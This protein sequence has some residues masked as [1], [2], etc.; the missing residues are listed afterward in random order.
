MYIKWWVE[1]DDEEGGR[2]RRGR[3]ADS[4]NV[5]MLQGL[6]EWYNLAPPKAKMLLSL[7]TCRRRWAM[8][9]FR[10]FV[11]SKTK[12]TTQDILTG[13]S[14]NINIRVTDYDRYTGSAPRQSFEQLEADMRLRLIQTQGQQLLIKVPS[15]V[16]ESASHGRRFE[17]VIYLIINHPARLSGYFIV[18]VRPHPVDERYWDKVKN[19]RLFLSRISKGWYTLRLARKAVVPQVHWLLLNKKRACL[20]SIFYFSARIQRRES[21]TGNKITTEVWSGA[22]IPWTCPCFWPIGEMME[23]MPRTQFVAEHLFWHVRATRSRGSCIFQ[24]LLWIL[25]CESR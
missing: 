24:A 6:R 13:G 3:K 25:A 18:C 5:F 16:S 2:R 7:A 12:K 17:M 20:A 1:D 9:N 22:V 4:N 21:E 15:S 14:I 10:M 11:L 8:E 23:A 19:M